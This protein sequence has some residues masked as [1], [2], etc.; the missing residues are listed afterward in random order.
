MIKL[1]GNSKIWVAFPTFEH[2]IIKREFLTTHECFLNILYMNV[3]GH[4]GIDSFFLS[5]IFA[6][7]KI[8]SWTT[9]F[10]CK[11]EFVIE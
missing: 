6:H 7:D 9:T 11:N 4:L 10:Q 2:A 3:H 5:N 1:I 8:L